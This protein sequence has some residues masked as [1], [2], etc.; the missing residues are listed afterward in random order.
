MKGSEFLRQ[1]ATAKPA[2]WEAAVLALARAGQLY[3]WPRVPVTMTDGTRTLVLQV[4]SD[5]LAVGEDGDV[6]RMP[7]TPLTAQRVFDALNMMLPTYKMVKAIYEQST[8]RLNTGG[9]VPNRYANLAQY[10]VQNA[11]IESELAGRRGLASGHKKDVVVGNQMRARNAIRS[12]NVLIYGWP[13]P[14]TIPEGSDV[15]PMMTAAWRIQTYS[16]VH[17]DGYVDYSHGEREIEPEPLL[18]GRPVHLA[19]VMQD[20]TLWKLVSDEGPLKATRYP[21]PRDA[22]STVATIPAGPR[23]VDQGLAWVQDQVLENKKESL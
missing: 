7:L 21:V 23:L 11:I 16:G 17:D 1:Y 19:D 2:E 12:G 4:A 22:S 9:L 20:R 14:G 5:Y 10:G 18:D 6:L 15:F 3:R 8:V 13:K